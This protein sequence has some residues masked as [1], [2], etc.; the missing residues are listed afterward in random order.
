MKLNKCALSITLA[1]ACAGVQAE[2]QYPSQAVRLIV[3]FPPGSSSD[4]TARAVAQKI[5]G[6]LG[7]PVVVENRPGAM[8]GIGMQAVARSKPDGHTLVV[9]TVS[10]TVV[11]P[12]ISKSVPVDLFKDFAP[13]ATMANTPLLLTV[14]QD[15]PFG[16]VADLVAAAKKTPKSLTYGSS[17][18]LYRIAMEA[19]NSSAG[20]DLLGVPFTSPPQALTELLAGRLTVNP[21]ALGAVGPMLQ[22]KRVRALAVLGSNR[23]P[24]LPDVPTM[25]ELGF[26][27]FAFNG[28]LGVLAPAGTPQ[29]VI[30]RL[31][32]EIAKAVATPDVQAL[33]TRLGMEATVLSPQAYGEEMRKD[34]AKYKAVAQQAGIE[35]E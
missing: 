16:S 18:G 8:G 17:A 6:P 12:I 30:E 27:G 22:A 35:K 7:Q 10:T 21:D 14:P 4:V 15:S 1:L 13:V 19:V 28:W 11:P 31:H 29:P 20:I 26:K 32:K 33:Y 25:Q 24:S 9:G 23:T 5:A 3:P 34:A 2:A